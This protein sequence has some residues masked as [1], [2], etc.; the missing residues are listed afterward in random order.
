MT[1]RRLRVDTR[2]RAYVYVADLVYR[3]S[4]IVYMVCTQ[5]SNGPR[6]AV[7]WRATRQKKNIKQYT[8]EEASR[9]EV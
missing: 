7:W 2:Y 5:N 4:D 8:E 9:F 6:L 3:I 1:A